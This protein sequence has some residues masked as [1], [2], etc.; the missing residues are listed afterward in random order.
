MCY[1]MNCEWKIV[2]SGCKQTTKDFVNCHSNESFLW[3]SLKSNRW[4]TL[5]PKKEVLVG[6][7]YCSFLVIVIVFPNITEAI[8]SDHSTPKLLNFTV[9]Q[10]IC[11]RFKKSP[12]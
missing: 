4:R 7:G 1:N 6:T 2:P 5:S 3:H 10:V 11:T 9:S 8:Q 12:P